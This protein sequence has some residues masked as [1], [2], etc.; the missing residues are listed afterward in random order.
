VTRLRVV[1][2]SRLSGAGSMRPPGM[3]REHL[4]VGDNMAGAR[5][6]SVVLLGFLGSCASQNRPA[7]TVF[8]LSGGAALSDVEEY[9][10]AARLTFEDRSAWF[11]FDTGAGVH[12][13]ARWYVE[14]A[15]MP[16]DT[17]SGGVTA[18]DA[19]GAPVALRFVRDQTG[20]FEGGAELSLSMAAVADFPAE[21]EEAE[22]GGLLNPQLLAAEGRAVVLDLRTSEFRLEPFGAA[23]RR[24]GARRVPAN[25]LRVCRS[26]AADIP[27]LL[28]AVLVRADGEEGWLQLDTGAGM[29]KLTT[30]SRL[31]K[32]LVLDAGGQTMGIA[33]Q[34]QDY[35]IARDLPLSFAGYRA[36]IDAHVAA[37]PLEG[38]GPDGLLGLDAVGRCAL[39]MSPDAVAL[40]CDG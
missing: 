4:R 13:L 11:I 37:S 40:A 17:A 29:T 22:I 2:S 27:N 24:L 26:A 31:V 35:R 6:L 5:V 12:T 18:H 15:G 19:T 34:P 16:L 28:F 9:G 23:V 3:N 39:V 21:F 25:E 36:T 38:C 10:I 33:G 14:A 7:Q 8:P 30:G 32:D 1:A 20:I